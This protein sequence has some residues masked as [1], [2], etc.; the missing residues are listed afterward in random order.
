[1][2]PSTDQAPLAG[3][4]NLVRRTATQDASGQA[5]ETFEGVGVICSATV[6]D[7]FGL[8]TAFVGVPLILGQLQV[9]DHA[10][11]GPSLFALA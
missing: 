2:R 8:G 5:T 9:G 1:M 3:G 10:A 4:H 11:V 6:V 7:D